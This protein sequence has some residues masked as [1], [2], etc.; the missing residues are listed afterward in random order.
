MAHAFNDWNVM[1]EHSVRIYEALQGKEV[2]IQAYF[3]QGGHGGP[4]PLRLM[5]RWFT[6]YLHDV[7][8]G[9]EDDPRAWIVREGDKQDDP[10]PYPD[11]PHPDASPVSLYPVPGSP[12]QGELSLTPATEPGTE[13]LV[14]NFSF[15][16]AA[17]A[18]AEWTNHRLIYVTPELT[19]EL[20]LSG[21]PSCTVRLASS[22]PSA[23]LSVWLLSL[24]WNDK[25][26][27]KITENIITRGWADPQNHRSLT[28]SEPLVPG[29]FYQL[30]FDLQPDDQI[31]PSG[32]KIGLM[33]FS[34][35]RD[36]TLRPDPGTELTV[37]LQST[38]LTLPVV[39]GRPA[40]TEATAS[41]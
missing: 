24:P 19:Q 39:G 22:K 28:E 10:T 21:T 40:Y 3:H 38:S 25:K 1:P 11:Y 36:F 5:N 18:Q 16:G 7:E 34:S 17:L 13:T 26:N 35:D 14:D 6:R 4:P 2:P 8:N 20:H 27:A 31:I 32:Q 23:N 12:R 33:I 29:Q 15:S 37:D 9:V 30:T 41:K